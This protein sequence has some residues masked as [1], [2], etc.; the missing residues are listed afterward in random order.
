MMKLTDAEFDRIVREKL[1]EVR[2]F[3]NEKQNKA[4]V[5]EHLDRLENNNHF[6][7]QF[8]VM[9]H[10]YQLTGLTCDGCVTTVK[11]L[12]REITGVQSIEINEACNEATI[13]MTQHVSTETL[14]ETLKN[15]PKYTITDKV[16][17]NVYPSVLTTFEE[18]KSWFAI[19]KPL[20]MV[21]AYITGIALLASWRGD[22]LNGMR[23][24]QFFMA[25]FFLA[26]SFS[27][28]LDL[29]GFADSYSSYDVL[30]KRWRG[31]GFIYPFM[32]LALGIAY[33]IDFNPFITNVTTVVV[34][35]FSIIGVL[36]S[37]LSKRKIRCACLGE[38]FNLPMST[39]TIIEDLLMVAMAA[40]M[41]FLMY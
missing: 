35:G 16:E 39:V 6:N 23:F 30:A 7:L 5:F 18:K 33:V 8:E 28:M 14:K 15:H 31:Y 32:E 26:F 25:G 13:T 3:P 22:T 21:F 19:Y 24:M 41:L 11:K 2:A 17:L 36:Q 20:L 34:M 4:I 1:N 29:S 12:L 27:K 9:T 38:F 40:I 10:Y 37:V